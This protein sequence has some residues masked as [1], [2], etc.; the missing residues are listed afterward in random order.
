MVISHSYV[1]LPEGNHIVQWCL[2]LGGMGLLCFSEVFHTKWRGPKSSQFFQLP[3]EGPEPGQP[4]L[5]AML[6]SSLGHRNPMPDS[7]IK[8]QGCSEIRNRM[9]NI[10]FQNICLIGMPNIVWKN[11]RSNVRMIECMS[12]R[13][14]FRIPHKLSDKMP[15]SM[16]VLFWGGSRSAIGTIH[17]DFKVWLWDHLQI[18]G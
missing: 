3:G 16:S 2:I 18:G 12:N 13:K 14:K 8:C 11:V 10:E 7:Q 6:A 9:P 15:D 17:V 5:L 1:S 4:A